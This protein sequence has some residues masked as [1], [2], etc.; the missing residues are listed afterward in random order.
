M[1]SPTKSREIPTRKNVTALFRGQAGRGFEE[2]TCAVSVEVVDREAPNVVCVGDSR[3]V[4]SSAGGQ[5]TATR[6]LPLPQV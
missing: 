3:L 4:F 6:Y 1:V 2:S 5:A